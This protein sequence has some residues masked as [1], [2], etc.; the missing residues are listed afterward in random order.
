[1]KPDIAVG[2]IGYGYWGPNLVRNLHKTP[3]FRVR[4]ISD[5]VP[6]RL[7]SALRIFP[8]ARGVASGEELLARGEVEAVAIATPVHTHYPLEREAPKSGYDVLLI[9]TVAMHSS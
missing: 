6:G 8:S 9:Q 2:V 4:A 1:M 5:A 7:A 3:G